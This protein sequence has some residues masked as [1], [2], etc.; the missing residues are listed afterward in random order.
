[1]NCANSKDAFHAALEQCIQ[2]CIQPMIVSTTVS[3]QYIDG[4]VTEPT[5]NHKFIPT[6]QNPEYVQCK[7]HFKRSFGFG[8]FLDE[9]RLLSYKS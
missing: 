3:V 6:S 8:I 1:M 5:V 7:L 4:S 2:Q 9:S